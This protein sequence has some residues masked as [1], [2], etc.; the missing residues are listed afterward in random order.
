[1]SRTIGPIA[2]AVDL[3]EACRT[4]GLDVRWTTDG[5]AVSI[6]RDVARVLRGSR[7]NPAREKCE[8]L[9]ANFL[10]AELECRHIGLSPR[11]TRRR[12]VA[13]PSR[14]TLLAQQG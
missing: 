13:R 14:R 5:L 9:Q 12:S 7:R 10:K 6:P 3:L 11:K 8:P 2:I 4:A 1:M